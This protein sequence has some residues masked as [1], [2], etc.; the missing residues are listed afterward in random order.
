MY[1]TVVDHMMHAYMYVCVSVVDH[2]TSIN[3]CW[4]LPV[5]INYEVQKQ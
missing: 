5:I 4:F 3:Y 1:V 2:M